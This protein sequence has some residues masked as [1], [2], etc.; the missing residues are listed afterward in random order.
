MTVKEL[1]EELQEYCNRDPNL[2]DFEVF[3]RNNSYTELSKG[4]EI[5]IYSIDFTKSLKEVYLD[6]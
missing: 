6:I 4:D 1:I 5:M 3:I 2:L